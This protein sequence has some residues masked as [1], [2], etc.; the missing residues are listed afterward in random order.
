[1]IPLG[2]NG[3]NNTA[4]YFIESI[5]HGETNKI[6]QS[7]PQTITATAADQLIGLNARLP[8]SYCGSFFKFKLII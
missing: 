3:L 2:G 7:I 6:Q 1:M 5:I 8:D 4:I